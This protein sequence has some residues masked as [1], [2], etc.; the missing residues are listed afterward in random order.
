MNNERW[1]NTYVLGSIHSYTLQD[2]HLQEGHL[3]CVGLDGLSAI[4]IQAFI[5]SP[6]MGICGLL[7]R[8]DLDSVLPGWNTRC[9]CDML[10]KWAYKR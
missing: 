3:K 6:S 8:R 5:V 9:L 10:V 2:S 7:E 4:T 1:R